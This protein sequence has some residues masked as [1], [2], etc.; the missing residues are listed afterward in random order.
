MSLSNDE[1][2]KIVESSFLKAD[3][4]FEVEPVCLEICGEYGNQTFATLGNF[5]VFIAPPKVGKTTATGVA[6]AALL[7]GRQISNFYPSLPNEKKMIVWVDTEQGKRECVKTIQLICNQATG[8]KLDHPACLVYSSLRKYGKDIRMEAIEYL[9]YNTPNIGFLVIDGIRDL[10][11]SIN[12]EREATIVADKLL[13]WTQEANIHILAVLHQNKGDANARGH[14][15]TELINKAETVATLS[16]GDNAG[17]RTTIIEPKFTRHK[18]FEPFAFTIDSGQI[19]EA[20]VSQRYEP[21]NPNVNQLTSRELESIVKLCFS[22]IQFLPYGKC[23]SGI[24]KAL[25]SMDIKYGDNRAK[26][27]LKRLV[28]ECYIIYNDQLKHYQANV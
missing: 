13:K 1:I 26:D 2:K 24:K 18:E 20:D 21:K 11:S 27:T 15:G 4:K 8:N 19:I 5:S 16:R 9:V 23:W 12:D 14:I 3:H 28:K 10:V 6:I 17:I 22:E 7:T 25:E